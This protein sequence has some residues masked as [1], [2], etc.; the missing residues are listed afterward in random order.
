MSAET[1]RVAYL[2]E[3]D[4]KILLG[5]E[6]DRIVPVGVGPG[7]EADRDAVIEEE[8]LG[9]GVGVA[10]D[11]NGI[12]AAAGIGAAPARRVLGISCELPRAIGDR[13]YRAIGDRIHVLSGT[14]IA[15]KTRKLRWLGRP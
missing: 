14:G 6:I 12:R 13:P 7:A 2:Q 3:L 8:G 1:N 4:R 11:P 10:D 9:P 15:R 5:D